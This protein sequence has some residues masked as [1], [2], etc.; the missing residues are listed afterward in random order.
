VL[1]RR[2]RSSADFIDALSSLLERG[3]ATRMA[4]ES[5]AA[6][7][8][9]AIARAVAMPD[10]ATEDAIAARIERPDL[11]EA[12]GRMRSLA[13]TGEAGD[14]F[15]RGVALAQQLR[16]EFAPHGRPRN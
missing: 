6:S 15:V 7:A 3:R 16:K 11:R 9:R 1:E 2:D 12:Y 14:D 10:G 8:S 4:A 13:A 5:A